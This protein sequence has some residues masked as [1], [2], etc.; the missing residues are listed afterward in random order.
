MVIDTVIFTKLED[1]L[2]NLQ[3]PKLIPAEY[4][5]LSVWGAQGSAPAAIT[6]RALLVP[7]TEEGSGTWSLCY[8]PAIVQVNLKKIK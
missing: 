3:G 5:H 1:V 7:L 2:R 4:P 6:P 8:D